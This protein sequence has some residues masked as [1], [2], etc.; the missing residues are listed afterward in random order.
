MAKINYSIRSTKTRQPVSIYVRLRDGKADLV[1]PIGKSIYPENWSQ[2]TQLTKQRIT[3]DDL[4]DPFTTE[5]KAGLD[6]YLTKFKVFLLSENNNSTEL[7][8][9]SNL[10]NEPLSKEEI[11]ANT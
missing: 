9:H 10:P 11:K 1:A 5:M 7:V 4:I 6:D 2:M 8:K 3:N